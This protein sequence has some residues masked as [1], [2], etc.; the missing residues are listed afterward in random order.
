M[1]SV[2]TGKSRVSDRGVG[3]REHV[4]GGI[5]TYHGPASSDRYDEHAE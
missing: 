4:I 1:T 5:G 3:D 2:F